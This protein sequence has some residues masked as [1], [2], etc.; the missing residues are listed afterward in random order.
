MNFTYVKGVEV[1]KMSKIS[2][3][4]SHVKEPLNYPKVQAGY[5]NLS[6]VIFATQINDMMADLTKKMVELKK[7]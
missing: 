2:A 5:E 6:Q 1:D 3:I 7:K 4:K